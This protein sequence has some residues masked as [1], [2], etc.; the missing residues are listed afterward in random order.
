MFVVN[1]MTSLWTSEI[2]T[3]LNDLETKTI[4]ENPL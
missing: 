1:A 2:N 3:R 4:R